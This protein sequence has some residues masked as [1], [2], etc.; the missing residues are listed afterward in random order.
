MATRK[1]ASSDAPT[2]DE[3]D[4][5]PTL[6]R[7]VELVGKRLMAGRPHDDSVT[8]WID[9]DPTSTYHLAQVV[10]MVL[11]YWALTRGRSEAEL[12]GDAQAGEGPAVQ[13]G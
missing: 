1:A 2:V 11:L 3:E 6:E 4:E 10:G 8:H 12:S 13:A 9:L 7:A 5:T